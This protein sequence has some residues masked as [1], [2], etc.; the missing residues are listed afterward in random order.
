MLFIVIPRVYNTSL[1]LL[2]KCCYDTRTRS[3][4]RRPYLLFYIF[5]PTPFL[6]QFCY[7]TVIL[8]F[9]FL[10]LGVTSLK[11]KFQPFLRTKTNKQ[12]NTVAL[13]ACC[14]ILPLI[15]QLSSSFTLI[16]CICVMKIPA[17]KRPVEANG[18]ITCR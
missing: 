6:L 18:I 16:K 8:H 7:I 13:H 10:I 4:V 9:F 11:Y 3:I 14:G 5:P 17:F 2:L 12:I 1:S 15:N